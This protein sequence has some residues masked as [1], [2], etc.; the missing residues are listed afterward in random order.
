MTPERW[1]QIS[2][3]YYTLLALPAEERCTI[4]T[5]LCGEDEKF[6]AEVDSL[7]SADQSAGT[8]LFRGAM[9]DAA[10][11]L[12]A[13]A[14]MG[15]GDRVGS[16][17]ILGLIGTG[18]SGEVYRARDEMLDRD[19]AIK[20]LNA[21]FASAPD[22]TLGREARVLASLNHSGIAAVYSLLE[23]NSTPAIV[24]ECVEGPTLSDRLSR[25][26]IPLNEALQLAH[27]LAGALEYAHERGIVHRDLKPAN[28]KI[29]ADGNL[30]ILDFGLAEFFPRTGDTGASLEIQSRESVPRRPLVAGTPPYMAPEQMEGKACDRRVDIW[31]FGVVLFELLATERPWPGRTTAELLDEVSQSEP[32]WN[33]LPKRLPHWLRELLE[34]CL[35]KD[36]KSRLRDIGDA[37]LA[38]EEYLANP[39][40]IPFGAPQ[41]VSSLRLRSVVAAAVLAS[42]SVLVG[43]TYQHVRV[44]ALQPLMRVSLGLGPEAA[45]S[46][47]WP[48]IAISRDSTKV[49]YG[50]KAPDGGFQLS[51]RR[52]D[53]QASVSLPGAEG[54][55]PFFS[56][57][58]RW[59]AFFANG[60]LKKV[61]IE[62]GTSVVLCDAPD[63]RGGTW[64]DDDEIVFAGHSQGGL[65]RVS[66]NGGEVSPITE[67]DKSMGEMTHRWPQ[68]LPG[69]SVVLFTVHN[70][71]IDY[72]FATIQSQDLKTGRRQLLVQ[73]GYFGRYFAPGYLLYVRSGTLFGAA[74]NLHPPKII[75]SALPVIGPVD[76]S[77][78]S[79]LANITAS[80]A[81]SLIYSLTS[82][83][84]LRRKIAWL[85]EAGRMETIRAAPGLYRSLRISPDGKFVAFSLGR[86]L[87]S[88]LWILDLNRSAMLRLTFAKGAS[89]GPVWT[90]DGKHIAFVSNRDGRWRMYWTRVDGAGSAQPITDGGA[91]IYPAS[92]APD[93]QHLCAIELNR[94]TSADVVILAIDNAESDHPRIG[95]PQPFVNSPAVENHPSFSPD[96]HFIAYTSAESGAGEVYVKP[97]P[98]DGVKWQISNE[99]GEKALWSRNGHRLFYVSSNG[100]QA[101]LMAVEYRIKRHA[102]SASKPRCWS[103]ERLSLSDVYRDFDVAPDGRMV[104]YTEAEP[105][106]NDDLSRFELLLN[107]PD[108]LKRRLHGTTR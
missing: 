59:I 103:Q 7:L 36:P 8:F 70:T 85:N 49:V 81:G 68:M 46:A 90:P 9:E 92:F 83:G 44:A 31:A 50:S 98:D 82:S 22:A 34:R 23:V 93:G 56:P 42:L 37:R 72:D 19:V 35:R 100:S 95:I 75:S 51:L 33:V 2:D 97:Y 91:P 89:E 57:D 21:E 78:I 29:T 27:Q 73:G 106:S 60:V 14:L 45:S 4:I 32:H 102:F 43:V 80:E 15:S 11:E 94:K 30:K 62:G 52:L 64:G 6:R 26:P 48:N 69:S 18:G 108:E 47:P 39:T 65:S 41:R 16:Y 24:M 71:L 12:T 13:S 74:M 76:N 63:P 3:V 38:I 10:G 101:R 105:P 107:L 55:F 25:G 77:T 79:G 61:S 88:D 54:I 58:G 86:E 104:V 20:L 96:G 66:A 5:E 1:E 99:G 40:S 84:Y 87:G 28:L 17:R 53:Q 67:L